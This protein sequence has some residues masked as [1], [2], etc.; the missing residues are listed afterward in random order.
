MLRF[1]VAIYLLMLSF[2]I[3]AK[4]EINVGMTAAFTGPTAE[5]GREIKNGIASYFQYLNNNGG[6]KGQKLNLIVKDDGYEP[7]RAAINMRALIEQDGVVAVLGNVGTPTAVVTVPIANE[8]KT[9]LFGAF[10]GGDVLRTE[11]LSRYVI[12]YRASYA[13]ETREMISG[14]LQ[15]GIQPEE[16]AFFTQRDSYGDAGFQ[17]AKE[18]LLAHGFED[19]MT[20]AHGRYTRNT[21]NIEGAAA[22]I[23]DAEIEPKAIIMAGSYEASAKFIK[24]IQQDLPN[25]LFV[26]LS[27]VGG[28]FLEK[29][30]GADIEN[31]IAIQAVPNPASILPIVIEYR[32][33]LKQYDA[34]LTPNIVSLEGYIVAKIFHQGLLKINGEITKESIIDGLESLTS[35][36]IGLGVDVSL[37]KQDHQAI[38]MLWLSG[39]KN[40]QFMDFE[41]DEL[42]DDGQ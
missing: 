19:T 36:D 39:L 28:Y 6:I 41:W 21:S 24:L 29:A 27:F 38:E 34:S 20:L 3:M 2:S 35:V 11:P 12:N 7:E 9:V 40:G 25:V 8:S 42:R 13:A 15:A 33:R 22:D 31:V 14:L 4:D 18:A 30:L 32:Q 10:S 26:N 23:L 17:G 5:L 16:I 37:S 1:S